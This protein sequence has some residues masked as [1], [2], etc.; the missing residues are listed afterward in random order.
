MIT[1]TFE[2]KY[3]ALRNLVLILLVLKVTLLHGCSSRFFLTLFLHVASG[4][5]SF[6]RHNSSERKLIVDVT[7]P[8]P[9]TTA[10][11]FIDLQLAICQSTIF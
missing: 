5:K 10:I 6:T 1:K 2:S 8:G 7:K 11:R 4:T 9:N 3:D